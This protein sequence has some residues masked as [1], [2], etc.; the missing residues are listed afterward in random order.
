MSDSSNRSANPTHLLWSEP[1]LEAL[2]LAQAMEL[3]TARPARLLGIATGR[4]GKAVAVGSVPVS[5]GTGLASGGRA[6]ALLTLMASLS[7]TERSCAHC[8]LFHRVWHSVQL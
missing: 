6:C 2:G 7:P 4:V 8:P 1:P 3:L 5:S